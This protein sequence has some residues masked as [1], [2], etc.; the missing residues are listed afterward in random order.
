LISFALQMAV[1]YIPGVSDIFKTEPLGV[2]D[3]LL[4]I[5][6]SSLPLWAMEAYKALHKPAPLVVTE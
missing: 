4:V 3:W 5:A 2:R 6:I 1:V